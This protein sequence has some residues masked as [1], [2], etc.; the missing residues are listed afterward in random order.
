[1]THAKM[2]LEDSLDW[3]GSL[4]GS[5]FTTDQMLE[6][7]EPTIKTALSSLTQAAGHHPVIK[8]VKQT[9]KQLK[10]KVYYFCGENDEVERTLPM[11][12]SDVNREKLQR[13]T[14]K[15][16]MAQGIS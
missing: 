6:L 4:G 3:K 5:S 14:A 16:I 1:M 7:F 8:L 15:H 11:F 13:M 2:I 10:V 9:S 12:R